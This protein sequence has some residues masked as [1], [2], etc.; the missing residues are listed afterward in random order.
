MKARLIILLLT[1]AVVLP[2]EAQHKRFNNSS[3]KVKNKIEELE[4]IKLIE[5]L[6][7]KE[8]DMLKF[9]NRR[10][11]FLERNNQLEEKR[12]KHIDDLRVELNDLDEQKGK[13]A[14]DEIIILDESILKNRRDFILSLKDILSN[15]QI[16]K[17]I[18]FERNFKKELKELL[19]KK[20]SK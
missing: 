15:K 2:V 14:I 8:E 16:V 4:K 5:I 19:L 11:E 10:K 6:D 18:I 3:Q 20:R 9:F 13:T 12:N 1:I 17:L 7:L